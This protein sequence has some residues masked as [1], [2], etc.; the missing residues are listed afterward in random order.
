MLNNGGR[1]YWVDVGNSIVRVL[2]AGSMQPRSHEDTKTATKKNLSTNE[3]RLEKGYKYVF[4]ARD[5]NSDRE[6]RKGAK[7][8]KKKL[9]HA[10]GNGAGG[11]GD[12]VRF[13]G[14][15]W[16]RLSYLPCHV[17]PEP[18]LVD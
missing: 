9:N 10:G 6:D 13:D 3:H 15:G 12:G 16:D 17:S 5:G 1:W 14:N 18:R 8:A 11:N 2:C 4:G 7:I